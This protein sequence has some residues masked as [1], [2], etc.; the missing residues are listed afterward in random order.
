MK[1]VFLSF[2][3][4]GFRF[5]SPEFA[6]RLHSRGKPSRREDLSLGPEQRLKA[7]PPRLE[8]MSRRREFRAAGPGSR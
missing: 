2:P 1:G 6:P 7:R 3:F 8:V 5:L 4:A